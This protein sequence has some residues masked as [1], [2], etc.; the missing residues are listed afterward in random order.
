MPTALAVALLQETQ[1]ETNDWLESRFCGFGSSLSCVGLCST[2]QSSSGR[3]LW[4][5]TLQAKTLR[6]RLFL[7]LLALCLA[8]R[9]S[10]AC[11]VLPL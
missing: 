11:R 7:R 3:E 6:A 1:S 8:L 4:F 5:V 10:E 2:Q 9:G